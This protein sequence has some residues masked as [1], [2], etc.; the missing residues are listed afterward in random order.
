MRIALLLI[1]IIASSLIVNSGIA[2]TKAWSNGGYSTNPANPVYGTHDWIAQ[3][4]LDWLPTSEKQ[5]IAD[6]LAAYLYGTELPDNSNASMPGHIGD[7]SKHHIYYYSNGSLQDDAAAVRASAEYAIALNLLNSGNYSGAAITAGTMS[8]YIAD[9][10]VWAHVMGAS[11]DWGAETGNNHEN[12]ENYVDTRT[13]SYND[14]Y[15][16]YLL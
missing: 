4:A 3:H 14:T 5:Y 15:S 2:Q 16:K 1:A 11:T 10:A 9:V 7:T 6:N 13:N 8:H 12:Y